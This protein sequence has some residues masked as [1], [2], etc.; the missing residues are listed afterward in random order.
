MLV[1]EAVSQGCR[2]TVACA[3]LGVLPRSVLRW[4]QSPEGDKRRGPLTKPSN[5]LTMKEREAV[6]AVCTAQEYQDLSPRQLVPL[7]ADRGSYL[8]SEATFY[9]ILKEAGLLV[10]RERTKPPQRREPNT[11]TAFAPNEVY[12]WD[13]TYLPTTVRGLFFYAYIFVDIYSRKIVGARVHARESAELAAGLINDIAEEEGLTGSTTVVVH[14]DNG[15]PMKGATMLATLRRLGVAPSFSRPS[16]SNDNAFSESL[17]RTLKCSV[18]Y[19]KGGFKDLAEARAW[20]AEFVKW[21][22][23][24]HKHSGIKYVSPGQRHRGEDRQILASR[25][26]VYKEAQ[27]KMTHRWSGNTRDW[28]YIDSVI[29]NK[30]QKNKPMEGDKDISMN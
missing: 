1:N 28:S 13:I 26:T 18:A 8:A 19:P 5:A 6:L 27:R 30:K 25:H 17:F 7:L 15:S 24:E 3:D 29:L 10:H 16:V 11:H 9:R 4:E 23:E 22:N 20:L 21:Y 2:R 14:A 12:S